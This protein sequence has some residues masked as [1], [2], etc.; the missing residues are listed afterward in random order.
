M[1]VIPF[2]G[3]V[4]VLAVL[5]IA[6]FFLVSKLGLDKPQ[7]PEQWEKAAIMKQLL[8]L[9]ERETSPATTSARLRGSSASKPSTAHLKPTVRATL[10]VRSKTS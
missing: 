7:R 8:A 3:I 1:M 2:I 6:A 9:S 5:A 10:P 4:T